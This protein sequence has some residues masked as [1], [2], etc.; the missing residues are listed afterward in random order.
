MKSLF[1]SAAIRHRASDRGP[2]PEAIRS[3]RWVF[4]SAML[5]AAATFGALYVEAVQAQ[6]SAVSFCNGYRNLNSVKDGLN[7][8][9]DCSSTHRKLSRADGLFR[10]SLTPT[11]SP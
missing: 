3:W 9:V 8:S 7:K 5:L 1:P 10:V 4:L 6:A 11:G 2:R